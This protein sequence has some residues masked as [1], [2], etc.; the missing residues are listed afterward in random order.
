[1]HCMLLE[2]C[3]YGKRELMILNMVQQ[4]VFGD[5]VHCEG[6][7]HHDLRGEITCGKEMRHY[8]LRNYINRNCENYPTHEVG[9]ICKLLDINNAG[10]P[11]I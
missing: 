9:P 5:V 4:G 8:R 11:G 1:M 10:V 6:G 2:N 3:C 7:Y